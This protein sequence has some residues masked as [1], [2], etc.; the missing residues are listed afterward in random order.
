M[1]G[2]D[3][4]CEVF[5]R[6]PIPVVADPDVEQLI[7][8]IFILFDSERRVHNIPNVDVRIAVTVIDIKLDPRRSATIPV[9]HASRAGLWNDVVHVR[10]DSHVHVTVLGG[11]SKL[12]LVGALIC[13]DLIVPNFHEAFGVAVVSDR[14]GIEAFP[15]IEGLKWNDKEPIIVGPWVEAVR[16]LSDECISPIRVVRT[17]QVIVAVEGPG[18]AN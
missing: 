14:E 3:L 6:R 1:L 8:G 11:R 17:P 2:V 12:V 4:D 15:S 18:V 10:F 16:N 9:F 7:G 5:C 13:I